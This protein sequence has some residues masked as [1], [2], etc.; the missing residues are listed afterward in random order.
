MQIKAKFVEKVSK[1]IFL[2][3]KKES[4]VTLFGVK[5]EENIYLPLRPV[6]ALDKIKNN[7][8]LEKIPVF[9]FMEG[10]FY[11]IGGDENFKL[12]SIYLKILTQKKKKAVKYIKG[13]I[14]D[15]VKKENYEDA[16]ILLKGLIQIEASEENYD[17]LVMLLEKL[18]SNDSSYDE[19]AIEMF[20]RA[21]KL[22]G[23]NKAAL[24]K[25]II[26]YEQKKYEDAWFNICTYIENSKDNSEKVLTL[27]KDL[28]NIRH[29]EKGK[30][31]VYE[32][33]E[34]ALQFLLPLLEEFNDDAVLN[35]N[36]AIAYRVLEEYETAIYYLK[37]AVAIDSAIVEVINELGINYAALSEYDNAIKYF[38]KAF[39]ATKAIEIC[40][41]LIMCYLNKGD[42]LNA[43]L[44]YDIAVKINPKDEIVIKLKSII[45]N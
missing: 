26:Y 32:K 34:E 33:P 36:I 23:Y 6:R 28:Q 29:Y 4:I 8:K 5:A 45:G 43:K 16:Y 18:R 11:V 40:T 27:K 15:E 44:H 25:A 14:F 1:L 9:F 20:S 35:L 42:L 22:E 2:E 24:N 31:L 19:E 17:K 10:M 37:K 21:E 30:V 39:E 38:R 12:N 3:F 41:N 13:I 7:E